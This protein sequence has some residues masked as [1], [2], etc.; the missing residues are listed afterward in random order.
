MTHAIDR[1]SLL[2]SS[3]AATAALAAPNFALAQAAPGKP[4]VARVDPVT[5]D[6]WGVK[7]TDPY[8]W[9]EA[10]GP[11]AGVCR[12]GWQR[13]GSYQGRPPFSFGG[14]TGAQSGRVSLLVQIIKAG[15]KAG[16]FAQ[17]RGGLLMEGLGLDLSSLTCLWRP[18]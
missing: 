8:R 10:E 4:P 17:D 12:P 13:G 7:V 18:T 3:A 1:R 6:L 14:G 15:Q 16:R 9:M 5:E 2:A 11:E